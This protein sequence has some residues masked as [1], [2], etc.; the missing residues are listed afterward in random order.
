ML[1]HGIGACGDK[2]KKSQNLNNVFEEICEY[3][4]NRKSLL[5][6]FDIKVYYFYNW[7]PSKQIL[8]G[9]DNQYP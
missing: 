3:I 1:L 7:I 4:E 9:K 5:N 6:F 8:S 2:Q